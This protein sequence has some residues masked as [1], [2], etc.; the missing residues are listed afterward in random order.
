MLAWVEGDDAA[1]AAQAGR[2]ASDNR[3]AAAPRA[4]YHLL[5]GGALVRAGDRAAGVAHLTEAASLAPLTFIAARAAA[6]TPTIP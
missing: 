2:L 3:L 5:A 1:C 4:L 6:L